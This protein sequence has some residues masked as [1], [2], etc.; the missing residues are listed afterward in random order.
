MAIAAFKY[1]MF[2]TA[3]ALQEYVVS[4]GGG[5]TTV[6]AIVFDAASSQFVLF[7]I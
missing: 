2:P 1:K 4:G 5:V 7:Y 3:R 6:T